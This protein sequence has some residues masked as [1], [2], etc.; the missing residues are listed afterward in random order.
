MG[1]F[2]L[3]TQ[4]QNR[5]R[6]RNTLLI[7]V[8]LMVIS[9]L[10]SIWFEKISADELLVLGSLLA[11][12][13]VMLI[14]VVIDWCHHCSIWMSAIQ[15]FFL[16]AVSAFPIFRGESGLGILESA[17]IASLGGGI[18]AIAVGLK[19]R[20]IQQ[21]LIGIRGWLILP[22]IG[23]T[24]GLVSSLIRVIAEFAS[25]ERMMDK[26]YWGYVIPALL[27]TIGLFIYLCVAVLRFF[28]KRKNAPKTVIR[29]IIA[30]LVAS[31]ALFIIWGLVSEW[32]GYGCK[33]ELLTPMFVLII[34]QGIA[35][36]IWIPYF[37]LSK[38]V[39]ATFIN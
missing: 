36:G 33:E 39:K 8:V 30:R 1:V 10:L 25:F 9:W 14:V 19:A 38:R 5:L 37:K 35:A 16:S 29:F 4:S 2:H 31:V 15:G 23:L 34:V 28:K 7:G 26:D 12:C 21:L 11:M 32:E 6:V 17:I 24:V 27:I 22:A 18:A 20:R 13:M 3:V